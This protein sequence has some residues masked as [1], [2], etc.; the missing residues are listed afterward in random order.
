MK[1]MPESIWHKVELCARVVDTFL[2]LVIEAI[3]LD[4]LYY[5]P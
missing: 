4:H 3:V 1:K 5:R 2:R